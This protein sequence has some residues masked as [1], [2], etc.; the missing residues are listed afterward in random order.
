M[1]ACICAPGEYMVQGAC[2]L[3]PDERFCDGLAVH[4]CPENRGTGPGP[5][6]T[7]ADCKCRPGYGWIAGACVLCQPGCP[8]TKKG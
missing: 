8:G 7:E 6:A 4:S 2:A 1:T 5:R 3:C